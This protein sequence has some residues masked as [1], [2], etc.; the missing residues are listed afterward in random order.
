MS[1]PPTRVD[2]F[3]WL[4]QV[5]AG[6]P[7]DVYDMA[8]AIALEQQQSRCQWDTYSVSLHGA[9]LRRAARWLA[10]RGHALGAL[11][12]DDMLGFVP[13]WDVGVTAGEAN[14]VLGAWA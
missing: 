3:A 9:A 11:S 10:L 4:E 7:G 12:N 5:D 14:Y 1:E 2:L 6:E 13:R 8:L